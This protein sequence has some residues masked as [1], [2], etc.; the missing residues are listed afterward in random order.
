VRVLVTGATGFVGRH[1]VA[2]LTRDGHRVRRLLR[3]PDSAAPAGDVEDVLHADGVLGLVDSDVADVDAVL[4]LAAAGVSPKVA[5]A[6]ELHDTNVRGTTHLLELVAAA[7]ITRVALLGTCAE[8]GR[9]ADAHAAI[10]PDAALEPL[11]PYPRSKAEGFARACA[12]VAGHGLSAHYL[13]LFTAFGEGQT[14]RALWPSLRAAALAGEDFPMTSGGQVRDF[15]PVEEVARTVV[16]MLDTPA[17]AGRLLVRNLGSGVGTS[18]L[19]FATDWWQRFG[20]SGRL[21]PGAIAD[22]S[23]EPQRYVA[24]V[25]TT[26]EAPASLTVGGSA[27]ASPQG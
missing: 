19:D 9:S 5:T 14:P 2:Q 11:S 4:H 20:A 22:R 3:Q 24:E 16:A 26:W 1:V 17:P 15:L 13:R 10:P 18:V 7:G 12:L 23:D 8:Y 6:E 25:G 21:L 27:G